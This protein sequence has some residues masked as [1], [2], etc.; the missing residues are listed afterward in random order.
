VKDNAKTSGLD[1]VKATQPEIGKIK[2]NWDR[3]HVSP[4]K[5][6]TSEVLVSFVCI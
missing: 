2:P 3:K 1:R 5:K 4:S 6:A